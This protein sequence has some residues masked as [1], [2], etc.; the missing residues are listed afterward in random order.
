LKKVLEYT[1][2]L[3]NGDLSEELHFKRLGKALN[4]ALNK[5]SSNIRLLV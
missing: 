2:K 4:K 5:A 3:G 1:E